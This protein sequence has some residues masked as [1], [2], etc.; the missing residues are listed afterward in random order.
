MTHTTD[1]CPTWHTEGH[2]AL[3]QTTPHFA[4]FCSPVFSQPCPLQQLF[5]VAASVS[6]FSTVNGCK[7]PFF[8]KR[9]PNSFIATS[10]T[11]ISHKRKQKENVFFL[12]AKNKT[13]LLLS[14]VIFTIRFL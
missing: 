1:N 2:P 13:D 12:T 7:E 4:C 11:E 9:H 14:P 6:H 10:R 3:A 5:S 8:L